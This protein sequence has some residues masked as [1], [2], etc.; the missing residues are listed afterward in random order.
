MNRAL[1]EKR[2]MALF[3][4]EKSIPERLILKQIFKEANLLS[5]DRPR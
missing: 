3:H 4:T 5:Y 2:V 1:V